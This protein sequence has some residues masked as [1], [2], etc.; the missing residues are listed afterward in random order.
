ML[1]KLPSP[2]QGHWQL[3]ERL[4]LRRRIHPP[5]SERLLQRQRRLHQRQQRT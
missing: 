4:L 2:R 5:F 1:V 3:S